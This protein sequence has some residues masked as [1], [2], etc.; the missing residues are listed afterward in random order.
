MKV[1]ASKLLDFHGARKYFGRPVTMHECLNFSRNNYK[2]FHGIPMARGWCVF[3][4]REENDNTPEPNIQQAIAE[5][6]AA[7][8]SLGS[9]IMNIA[10]NSFVAAERTQEFAEACRNSEEEN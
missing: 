10:A 8:A 9:S 1:R 6:E 7:I 3:K 2:K 4:F 5:C